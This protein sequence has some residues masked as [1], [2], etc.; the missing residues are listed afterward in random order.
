MHLLLDTDA[1]CMFADVG[2]LERAARA[3]GVNW[4]DCS[5]L[6]ALPYM[7]RRGRLR[8]RLGE[9]RSDRLLPTALTISVAPTPLPLWA[10]RLLGIQDMDP[11]E[12]QL[13]A[14]SA[15]RGFLLLTGDKR[16]VTAVRNI[17]VFVDALRGRIILPEVLLLLLCELDGDKYIRN[18]FKTGQGEDKMLQVVFSDD[19]PSPRDALNSYIA[20]ATSDLAPLVLWSPM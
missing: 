19:N 5:R 20:R 6:P 13:L 14:L 16:A 2:L 9:K 7:L 15:E 8:N 18:A 10:D 3:I 4:G 17:G 11:G 12:A 1:F